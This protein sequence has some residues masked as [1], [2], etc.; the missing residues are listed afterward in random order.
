MVRPSEAPSPRERLTVGTLVSYVALLVGSGSHGLAAEMIG[1][2][3]QAMTIPMSGK[4]ESLNAA[5]AGSIAMY[6]LAAR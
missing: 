1:H 4:T 6:S 2:C 5:V 3:D